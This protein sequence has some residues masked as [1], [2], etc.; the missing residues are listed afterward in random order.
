MSNTLYIYISY[1]CWYDVFD[2]IIWC[3]SLLASSTFRS[4]YDSNGFGPGLVMPC[5]SHPTPPGS[6]PLGVSTVMLQGLF[7]LRQFHL[8]A[9]HVLHHSSAVFL[10]LR[11]RFILSPPTLFTS[12]KWIFDHSVAYYTPSYIWDIL[13]FI[14]VV[15]HLLCGMHPRPKEVW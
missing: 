10:G 7:Q 15:N 2:A 3:L 12:Y 11:H 9:R 4:M 6:R 1:W 8:Q 5:G 13:G 14:W